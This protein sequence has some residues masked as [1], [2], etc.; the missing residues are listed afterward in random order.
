M[1]G[2]FI[3]MKKIQII[4]NTY[5][6][7]DMLLKLIK[8]I[9]S[10][11]GL[12]EFDILIFKDYSEVSYKKCIQYLHKSFKWP[13]E[14][15]KMEQHCGKKNYWRIIDMAYRELKDKKY[16]YLFH[17]Q[18]DLGLEPCFFQEAIRQWDAI[19]DPK[20]SVMNLLRDYSRN[21]PMWTTV[22]PELKKFDDVQVYS[23]GWVDCCYIA[24][25]NFPGIMEW[26]LNPVSDAWS[27]NPEKSSGVGMQMSRRLVDGGYTLWHV[28][29]TL[30]THGAHDSV[31]HPEHRKHTPLIA[32]SEKVIASVCSM[33]E[34]ETSLKKVI[35]SVINQVDQVWVYLNEY[36]SVPSFL[37]NDKIRVFR[38]QDEIGDIGDAGKF[39]GC[40][41]IKGYHFTLDDDLI[42][43]SDYVA[44]M[45]AAIEVN[46]RKYA[47]TLHGRI[48]N[49]LPVNSYYH[50]ATG[51]CSCL[52]DQTA[53]T[54]VHVGGTGV[55]AY[56]TDTIQISM[57]DFK[58]ANMS[59]I[60]FAKVCAEQNVPILS[61]S[62]K[63][64]WIKES[65][66]DHNRTIYSSCNSSDRY[67][68]EVLNAIPF[69]VL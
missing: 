32:N 43:P 37:V 13:H 63:K 49:R 52:L 28:K 36:A 20:K 69:T 18:D 27:G 4:I 51:R 58:A 19:R 64:G 50:G 24:G 66:Y 12:Y 42:Y 59:D 65:T 61:L 6:R 35:A 10:Y 30:V 25:R 26:K 15:I 29:K 23:T 48:F 7:P 67:Q 54:F 45:I 38:S 34:R 16:D 41:K 60:W 68:T 57:A 62:H 9:N 21:G 8:Q 56:H 46:N 53:D 44:R 40:E 3:I 5:Q 14:W 33:P 22:V 47:I 17:I 39:Y 1:W 2:F 31:M 11:A 55:G